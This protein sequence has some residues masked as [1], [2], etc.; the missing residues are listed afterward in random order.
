MK[1]IIDRFEGNY[2]VVEL[3]DGTMKDILKNQLPLGSDEG[4]VLNINKKITIN[5]EE[6]HKRKKEIRKFSNDLWE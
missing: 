3:Y 6:T 1:G 2:A 4:T 5:Q